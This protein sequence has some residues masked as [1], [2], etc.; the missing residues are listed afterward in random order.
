VAA[1]GGLCVTSVCAR[2]LVCVFGAR[3]SPQDEAVG[4]EIQLNNNLGLTWEMMGNKQLG[5]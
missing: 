4:Q 2:E 1:R 3:E 5:S